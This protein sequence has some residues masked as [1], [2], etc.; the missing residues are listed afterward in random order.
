MKLS[1]LLALLV[2]VSSVAQAQSVPN[3]I[4]YQ[5]H[6]LDANGAPI[7]AGTPVNRTVTFRLWNHPSSSSEADNLIYSEKQTVTIADGEFSVLVGD[8][9]AVSGEAAKGPPTLTLGSAVVFG[10]PDRYLGVTVD[11]GVPATPDAEISP[12]QRIASSAF[13][14]RAKFADSVG[15]ASGSSV[16]VTTDGKVGIRTSTPSA[17]YDVDMVG[18]VRATAQITSA[19][20]NFGPASTQGNNTFKGIALSGDSNGNGTI[21]SSIEGFAW[22]NLL[23]CPPP[24]TSNVGI[25]TLTPTAK[26]DVA[27]EIK[28]T[29][30]TAPTLTA[31][32]TVRGLSG[33]FG[34]TNV[35]NNP[36]GIRLTGDTASGIVQAESVAV[37]NLPLLLNPNGGNVGIGIATPTARL[38]VAGTVKA[39]GF[40]S[41]GSFDVATVN[42]GNAVKVSLQNDS[43][44]PLRGMILAH[45]PGQYYADLTINPDG[46]LVGIGT[47]VPHTTLDVAGVARASTSM[48]TVTGI[49]GTIKDTTN[50]NNTSHAGVVIYGSS[51]GGGIQAEDTGISN[52]PLALNPNGGNVGIGLGSNPTSGVPNAPT[53]GRLHIAGS[54]TNS[55]FPAHT[56]YSSGPSAVGAN[57][58]LTVSLYASNDILTAGLFRTAS[59]ERI[60]IIQGISDKKADLA[61]LMGIEVTNYT[62][63]DKVE[64]GGRVQKKVIAQQVAK[65]FPSAV[66]ESVNVVPD[67]YQRATSRD[68]WVQLATDLKK[69][70]RVRLLADEGE[71]LAEVLEVAEGR[72]RTAFQPKSGKLFVYGREVK[73]F[74]TV[75]YDAISMLNVSA[76]Q[77]IKREK[78]AEVAALRA[79][80]AAQAKRIAELEANAKQVDAK[81]AAIEN[82]LNSA[83]RKPALI[84][85]ASLK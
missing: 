57:A 50:A 59:D 75:D 16:T 26:L 77:Q 18:S 41:S 9:E 85:T 20:G 55:T 73:D 42:A 34:G 2:T 39:T 4:S 46:G 45:N 29:T 37:G 43:V 82:L 5:G 67:I 80:N 35:T 24:A 72:F 12:R 65:V 17:G 52:L 23:I 22:T 33:V 47:H 48:Q 21:N 8:G 53:L 58:N 84:K 51:A 68:G 81:L 74:R 10:A 61:T 28:A 63:K 19:Q 56:Q 76:T 64:H 3:L 69:G 38:D 27:G 32:G 66:S 44:E 15:S 79:E 14:M 71:Q 7:G 40:A 6:V 70:E 30:V 11:D 13:A 31:T 60:K 62:Y 78:D 54:V 83:D 36:T 25:G 1:L 49:F